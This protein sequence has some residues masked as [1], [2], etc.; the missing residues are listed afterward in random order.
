M[1]H[2]PDRSPDRSPGHSPGHSPDRNPTPSA[3]S[4][5][6]TVPA[7]HDP[8]PQ[9]PV[10]PALED[11]CG[12]GCTPCIFDL[13]QDA[14]DRYEAALEAWRGRQ[15]LAQAAGPEGGTGSGG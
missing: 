2:D 9:P 13:Y 15:P 14:Y 7:R 1:N 8:A 11:C 5:R 3:V 12:N 10:E 4:Y 6:S